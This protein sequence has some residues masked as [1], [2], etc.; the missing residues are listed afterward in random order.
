[1]V[2]E[3]Q[4]LVT[5]D[6]SNSEEERG[7]KVGSYWFKTGCPKSVKT[8]YL[9]AMMFSES[10]TEQHGNVLQPTMHLQNECF[11]EDCFTSSN[12]DEMKSADNEPFS[13][14]MCSD[15]DH[16]VDVDN[17]NAGITILYVRIQL[18]TN[19][20]I[21]CMY[22]DAL[23]LIEGTTHS[24]SSPF[25]TKSAQES[26]WACKCVIW[27]AYVYLSMICTHATATYNVIG[28]TIRTV[29]VLNRYFKPSQD[30]RTSLLH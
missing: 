27:V 21:M 19:D 10:L 7:I 25:L 11:I 5:Q 23:A 8:M 2:A 22:S 15:D 3:Q 1:M 20:S 12:H 17:K 9:Q 4:V 29:Y 13:L 24:L 18:N 26:P 28:N 6:T 30:D 14:V 16:I